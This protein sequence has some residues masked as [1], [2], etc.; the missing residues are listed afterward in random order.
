MSSSL[1][2]SISVPLHTIAL[3]SCSQ[4]GCVNL[5]MLCGQTILASDEKADFRES[6]VLVFCLSD[7]TK[8]MSLD[9]LAYPPDRS[10]RSDGLY[11]LVFSA[12]EIF[13]LQPQLGIFLTDAQD[14]CWV[15]SPLQTTGR[16]FLVYR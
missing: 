12:G 7:M 5:M 3:D 10:S 14:S 13:I 15:V 1:V 6:S 9:Q 2:D 16:N 8:Q 11:F 4:S